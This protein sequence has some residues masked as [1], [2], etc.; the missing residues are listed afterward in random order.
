[1]Q[2]VAVIRGGT[3]HEHEHFYAASESILSSLRLL[4]RSH[5]D[6][7]LS[8]N[9]R[10]LHNGRVREL[11]DILSG[12]DVVFLMIPRDCALRSDIESYL[13]LGRFAT[14]GMNTPAAARLIDVARLTRQTS[15]LAD[16]REV[17]VFG[18][19]SFRDQPQYI[20]TP[21]ERISDHQPKHNRPVWLTSELSAQLANQTKASVQDLDLPIWRATFQVLD[22]RAELTAI[23]SDAD[24]L[25]SPA[26]RTSCEL[27][28]LSYKHLLDHLIQTV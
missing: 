8:K 21:L 7:T 13:R 14:V 11:G 24:L 3:T 10:L 6:V 25:F 28:G 17:S 26:L 18:V 5:H 19:R 20:F 9:G 16:V 4:E 1:M 2:T 12:I 23:R 27:A 15:T 22:D